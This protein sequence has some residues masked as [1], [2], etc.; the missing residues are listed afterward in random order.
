[1]IP[2][3]HPTASMYMTLK[4]ITRILTDDYGRDT[5]NRMTTTEVE[6]ATATLRD[7]GSVF[8]HEANLWFVPDGEGLYAAYV[9]ESS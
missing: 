9:K 5:G 3:D 8:L 1:M 7:G 4:D 6:Q 2:D